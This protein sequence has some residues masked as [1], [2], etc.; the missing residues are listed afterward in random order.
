MNRLGCWRMNLTINYAGLEIPV[1]GWYTRDRSDAGPEEDFE[2]DEYTGP[3]ELDESLLESLCI[4]E[5]RSLGE[6]AS[7]QH[8]E[9]G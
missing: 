7:D 4:E 5:C 3:D 1:S 8:H 6:S 2:I 9:G